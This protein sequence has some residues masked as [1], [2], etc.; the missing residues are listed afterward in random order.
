MVVNMARDPKKGEPMTWQDFFP[1]PGS[2]K[3]GPE[4]S[5]DQQYQMF[6]MWAHAHNAMIERQGGPH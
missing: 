6:R 4:Y 2:R 5:E 1:P 3:N